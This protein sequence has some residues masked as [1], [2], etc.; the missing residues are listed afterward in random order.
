MADRASP[1][2]APLV[3]EGGS[4]LGGDGKAGRAI[5]RKTAGKNTATS[6]P[7]PQTAAETAAKG[8]MM[9]KTADTRTTTVRGGAKKPAAKKTGEAKQT[10]KTTPPTPSRTVAETERIRAAL[11][12]RREE[13][14]EEY[15][16]HRAE[17]AELQRD[18]LTDSAGDDQADTGS[19]TFEREQEISL[20][21]SILERINQ[22]DRAMERLDEGTYGWCERCGT[23]IPV[24]RL[25]AFPSATLCVT[26]KQLE[27]RR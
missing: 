16:Q 27:E 9:A 1:K 23:A 25:A 6:V 10:G 3:G 4:P 18:R 15:Q 14:H 13:L 26:C 17:I 20:A 24:E 5:S 2:A 21:N 11:A 12:A 22:V 8:A 19:K 7:A